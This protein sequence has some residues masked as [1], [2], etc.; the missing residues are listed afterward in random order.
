[1]ESF[2][3]ESLRIAILTEKRSFDF[4]HCAAGLVDDERTR[5]V[6]ERLA[7]EE[8]EHMKAFLE[9]YPGDEFGDLQSLTN[10]S[11]DPNNPGYRA[12]HEETDV[13]SREQQALK[14][15]LHEEQV[16]IEHYAVLATYLSERSLYEIF[17]K[18]LSETRRHYE[19]INEEYL[20]LMGMIGLPDQDVLSA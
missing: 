20:R 6:F 16:C 15:S 9:L 8:V 5:E 13:A 19:L 2:A 10:R 12:L 17:E 1:M 11:P 14:I 7:D 4:Y 3:K 18:V